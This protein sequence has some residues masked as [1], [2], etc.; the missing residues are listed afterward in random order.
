M[1]THQ[2]G[3]NTTGKNTER[4][5]PGTTTNGMCCRPGVPNTAGQTHHLV[6]VCSDPATVQPSVN[7]LQQ[8]HRL[9]PSTLCHL[10]CILFRAEQVGGSPHARGNNLALATPAAQPV[11]HYWVSSFSSETVAGFSLGRDTNLSLSCIFFHPDTLAHSPDE[12][13][14]CR[15]GMTWEHRS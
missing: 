1:V 14:R 8:R 6:P 2:I 11:T 9:S 12:N 5:M 7:G 15:H 10:L 4:G 3:S 13:M